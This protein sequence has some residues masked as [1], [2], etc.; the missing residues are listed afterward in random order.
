MEFNNVVENRRSARLF[1]NKIVTDEE[2]EMILKSGALA[3][4]A[5]NRQPWKFYVLSDEQK[6]YIMNMLFKWDKENPKERTS[7]KGSAEQ[8]KSASKM[9]MIYSDKYKS[10]FKIENYKKPDYLSIGCS[11]E[12]MSLQAVNLGLGSC[13]LC[14]TLYIENEINDYLK[15]KNF[16]QICGL[17]IGEPIYDYP[18]KIKKNLSELILS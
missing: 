6:N 3:P 14:D 13:I 17:I 4:S 9:I 10:K 12:N 5:H 1:S 2:L 16:E 8:I 18:P 7:V 11:L 15:I